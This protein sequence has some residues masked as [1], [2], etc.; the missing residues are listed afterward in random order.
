MVE[1]VMQAGD[2]LI[3]LS[4]SGNSGNVV[5]AFEA[6]RAKNVITIGF[7]GE[8]GGK[9]AVLSDIL[10]NVP[11]TVTP[12]IQ[13]VHMLAGHIICELVEAKLFPSS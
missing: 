8:T 9:M 12:R 2:V 1:G 3:G 6:A 7:T 10:F 4:T 13:E 5:K 11:S